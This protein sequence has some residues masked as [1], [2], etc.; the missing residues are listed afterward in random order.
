MPLP[1]KRQAHKNIIDPFD[2]GSDV[3]YSSDIQYINGK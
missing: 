3:E 1:E 2:R